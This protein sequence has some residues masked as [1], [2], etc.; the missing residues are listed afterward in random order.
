MA[1]M[2]A[3]GSYGDRRLWR[4]AA[5]V[6][7]AAALAQA[8]VAGGYGSHNHVSLYFSNKADIYL[9][10]A[11]IWDLRSVQGSSTK[12]ERRKE[13]LTSPF[14]RVIEFISTHNTP[15]NGNMK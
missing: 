1:E 10:A 4:Q 15:T 13:I 2:A 11:I 9:A 5:A 7:T 3:T 12:S 14:L 8:M 6:A